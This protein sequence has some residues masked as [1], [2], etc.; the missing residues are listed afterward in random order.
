MLEKIY[1][2][3]FRNFSEGRL[4]EFSD[5]KTVIVGPNAT[6]KTNI[7]EAINLLATGKSFRANR[8]EE[9]MGHKNEITRVKG[10]IKNNKN[11]YEVEETKLE[12]VLTRG[13]V[14]IAENKK[15]KA[16]KKRLLVNSVPKRLVDFAGVFKTVIFAPQDMDLVSGSPSLRRSFL[17]AVLY[18]A[19][20][21]Y[22]RTSI[23]YKKAV[24]RRNKILLKIREGQG[25]RSELTFWNKLLIKNGDYIALKRQ[26][27][28]D[29]VNN[30]EKLPDLKL[31]IVYDKNAISESRLEKYK[32]EEIYA[33]T[34]LV[35]PHRD[36]FNVQM[37]NGSG[38]HRNIDSFGSRGQQ[39]MGILWIKVSELKFLK[40]VT[41][42]KP[43]LLLDDIFSEL[44]HKHR[45]IVFSVLGQYQSVITTADPHYLQGI[46][47]V[48][49]IDL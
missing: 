39:R 30:S 24:R 10:L 15:Q 38:S 19:D 27:F 35:G 11:D 5:K 40:D 6:G 46:K 3:N 36:D 48:E 18:Q 21:E 33:A 31:R 37:K 45:E 16:P 44:D 12:V 7:L 49:K 42:E 14:N 28:I 1:L 13:V 2:K 26:E 17:D 43:T 32:N 29:F 34:T 8:Q 20:R 25:K 23:S 47:E 22:R 4:F 41:K 9:M